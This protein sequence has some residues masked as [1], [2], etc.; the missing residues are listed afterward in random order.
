MNGIFITLG[1]ALSTCHSLEASVFA[2]CSNLVAIMSLPTG[3]NVQET[4]LINYFN[5]AKTAVKKMSFHTRIQKL[6]QLAPKVFNPDVIEVLLQAKK[7]RNEIAHDFMSENSFLL[8]RQI[9][10]SC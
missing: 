6:G 2:M 7:I 4:E 1:K 3:G 9:I 8:L 5:D 10:V